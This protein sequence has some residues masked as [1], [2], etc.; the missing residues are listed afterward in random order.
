MAGGIGGHHGSSGGVASSSFHFL[1]QFHLQWWLVLHPKR[2]RPLAHQLLPV[3]P[4]SSLSCVFVAQEL[5]IVMVADGGRQ[6]SGYGM[7]SIRR[8]LVA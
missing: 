4:E 5:V 7:S 1:P 2:D 6:N 8:S 3:L